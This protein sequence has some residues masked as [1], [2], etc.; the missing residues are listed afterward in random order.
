MEHFLCSQ[1]ILLGRA[2]IKKALGRL[3]KWPCRYCLKSNIV[4]CRVLHV[5]WNK[6]VHQYSLGLTN[7]NTALEERPWELW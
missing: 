1:Q 4:R 3:E 6:P 5:R 7:C 2:A